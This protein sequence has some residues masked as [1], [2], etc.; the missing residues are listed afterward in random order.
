MLES[1]GSGNFSPLVL[2]G[3]ADLHLGLIMQFGFSW[4][5]SCYS[6]DR[7]KLWFQDSLCTDLSCLTVVPFPEPG[8]PPYGHLGLGHFTCRFLQKWAISKTA[9]ETVKNFQLVQSAA[10]EQ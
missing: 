1:S 3:A 5:L 6:K 2:N 7:W 8:D 10:A 4:C 9:L